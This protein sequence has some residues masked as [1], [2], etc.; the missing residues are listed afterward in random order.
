MIAIILGVVIAVLVVVA[1]V[2]S[3]YRR[4]DPDAAGPG[5]DGLGAGSSLGQVPGYMPGMR[6]KQERYDEASSALV[7]PPQPRDAAVDL[8]ANTVRVTR[9]D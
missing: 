9:H 1:A 6:Q 7:E 5:A 2:R 3:T 4:R 8:D